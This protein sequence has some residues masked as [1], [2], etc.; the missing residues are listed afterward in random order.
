MKG[1]LRTS[2]KHPDDLCRDG[3]NDEWKYKNLELL[4]YSMTN[5]HV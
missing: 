2:M 4:D 3:E 1:L 5:M